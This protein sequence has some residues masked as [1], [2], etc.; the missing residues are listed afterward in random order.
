MKHAT[1]L[2]L[3]LAA[4]APFAALAETPRSADEAVKAVL[5]AA[6]AGV[7]KED[8]AARLRRDALREA[9]QVYGSQSGWA[10]RW[11]VLENQLMGRD[12]ALSE[13]FRFN[14]FYLRGGVLQPPILDV[15]ADV[16]II[17][18]GGN[19]QQ[20]I[21]RVYRVLVPARLTHTPL[22]WRDFLLPNREQTVAPPREALLPKDA[23]DRKLWEEGV[24]AGWDQGERQANEEFTERLTT[25]NNAF[26]GMALYT[27][28]AM[29]GMI[30]PPNVLDTSE[31]TEVGAD[32]KTLAVNRRERVIARESYFVGDPGRWQPLQL[33]ATLS[34]P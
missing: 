34:P 5:D 23:K 6:V 12:Q 22:T 18:E 4:M 1:R 31:G 15:G 13:V 21:D 29:R 17:N 16:S 32:G 28:L 9:A 11:R 8:G 2:A 10:S 20:L 27:M 33:D 19:L 30:E 7:P 25:L 3:L 24:R 14:T 26:Q